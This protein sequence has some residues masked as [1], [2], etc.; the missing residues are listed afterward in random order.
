[1]KKNKTL[2]YVF[3]IIITIILIGCNKKSEIINNSE[4][5]N[6]ASQRKNNK[7]LAYSHSI[8]IETTETLIQKQYNDTIN[9]CTEATDFK[10]VILDSKLN[11]GEY[12]DGHVKLRVEPKGV[13]KIIQIATV[14]GEV[15]SKSTHVEDLAKPV[16]DN[17]KRRLMLETHRDRL[18]ELQKRSDNDIESLITISTELAKI[19]SEL[20]QAEGDNAHLIERT[21]LDILDIFFQ[22]EY[23]K[24][25]WKPI[26][27]SIKNFSSNLSK[28]IS[29]TILAIG[30]LIP[31]FITL[32]IAFIFLRFVW[33]KTSRKN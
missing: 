21:E 5:D 16:K 30:Y 27:Q 13:N 29:E 19:Q 26:I 15:S 23:Y 6:Y 9:A 2:F 12:T 31:W 17:Q 4:G 11:I 18:I 24:S 3:L 8:S 33:G 1:M 28:G 7:F 14:E 32:I 25:F 20:E 22:V 10:C